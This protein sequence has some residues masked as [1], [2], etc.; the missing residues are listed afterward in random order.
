LGTALPKGVA[1]KASLPVSG[2][3][4]FDRSHSWLDHP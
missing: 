4:F 1:A 3:W 2:S